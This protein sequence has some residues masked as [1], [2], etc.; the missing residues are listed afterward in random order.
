VSYARRDIDAVS[1]ARTG[2]AL[3]GRY[4]RWIVAAGVAAPTAG[5]LLAGYLFAA[6]QTP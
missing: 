5:V 2:V 4:S 1:D 6:A 3:T